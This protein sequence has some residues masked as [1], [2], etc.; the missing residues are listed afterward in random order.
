V[1]GEFAGIQG[2][3]LRLY[4]DLDHI[5]TSLLS[6]AVSQAN[7]RFIPVPGLSS[8]YQDIGPGAPIE[9]VIIGTSHEGVVAVSSYEG[10]TAV[11]AKEAIVASISLKPVIAIASSDLVIAVTP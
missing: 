6:K 9:E 7:D 10:V 2:P 4:P 8:L 5:A 3:Q 11:L 1:R